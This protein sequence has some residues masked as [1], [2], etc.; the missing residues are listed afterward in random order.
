[1]KPYWA[2]EGERG[3]RAEH[4]K[5][6]ANLEALYIGTK[7]R[8]FGIGTGRTPNPDEIYRDC[9]WAARVM[10]SLKFFGLDV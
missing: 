3:G 5:H 2:E 9:R 10:G 4:G 6:I 8:R 7:T 1:V